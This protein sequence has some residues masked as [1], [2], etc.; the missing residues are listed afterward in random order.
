MLREED[1]LRENFPDESHPLFVK[2]FSEAVQFRY[3]SDEAHPC[4]VETFSEAEF[5]RL[6]LYSLLVPYA[7]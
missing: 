6:S 7:T 1:I 4:F 5:R 2:I 3:C